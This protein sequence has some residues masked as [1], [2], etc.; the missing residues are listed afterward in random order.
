MGTRGVSVGSA[1][2]GLR[3]R[4]PSTPVNLACSST[5]ISSYRTPLAGGGAS[6]GR[7]P[8]PWRQ[9]HKRMPPPSPASGVVTPS[10][11]SPSLIRSRHNPGAN[12]SASPLSRAANSPS[13]K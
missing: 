3:Q 12:S 7:L 13:P 10:P 9:Q 1:P 2:A 4:A 8:S 6:A 5:N 11:F